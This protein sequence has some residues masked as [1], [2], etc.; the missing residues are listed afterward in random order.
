MLRPIKVGMATVAMA[1]TLTMSLLA[2]T[3]QA[4]MRMT[5]ISVSQSQGDEG[6]L[7]KLLISPQWGL[8]VS[9]IKTGEHIQQVRIGDPSR[10]V[11]DFDSPLEGRGGGSASVI[12][13][14]QLSQPLD[15]DLRLPGAARY[16]N[17]VPMSVVTQGRQGLNFYQFQ[18]SLGEA[19]HHSAVEV[20]PDALMPRP[21]SRPRIE[22]PREIQPGERPLPP[23]DPK[24]S[25][26]M[27]V[28]LRSIPQRTP[29]IVQAP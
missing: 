25:N 24:G 26:A 6:A 5:R 22:L 2:A 29:H 14:R 11:T 7:P 16:S 9:F 21:Q 13:L 23:L 28:R 18:L 15:L 12:Y 27:P 19:T 4:E 8:A 3:A 20:V 10:I 17:Q 1:T